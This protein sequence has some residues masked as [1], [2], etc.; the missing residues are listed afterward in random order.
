[1]PVLGLLQNLAATPVFLLAQADAGEPGAPLAFSPVK[2]IVVL[3]WVFLSFY[4]VKWIEDSPIVAPQY[5]PLLRVVALFVGPVVLV[6]LLLADTKQAA[7][8]GN[9][10][11]RAIQRVLGGLTR[12]LGA[13]A[14]EEAEE[15]SQLQLFDSLGTELRDLYGHGSGK[16]DAHVLD[17]T[18]KM[19]DNALR[20]RASD[21]LIDPK[22]QEAYAVRFRVDGTLRTI[23]ELPAET[24]KT[25][26]NSVK[27]VSNMDISERRRPQDGAF[28]AK[29]GEARFSFRVASAGALN[30]EK[31]SIRVLNQNADKFT[32]AQAGMPER[33]RLAIVSAVSKPSG[34]VLI[35][36]PTGSGKT[37]TLYSMLNQI[38]RRT[39]N[40][41]TVED[42][43]EAHL[44]ECSQLE[45]NPKADITFAK[46]LRSILRQDPDV[47]VVGEIRDEETAEIALR[48]AQ[49][50]HLVLATIHCDSNATALIRLLDLGVSAILMSTGLNLVVSQR[51][52]RKLCK[53]CRQPAQLAPAVAQRFRQKG[54]DPGQLFE[55]VGCERC[56]GT[57]Y[58]GRT[59]I[60]DMLPITE[61][62]RAE[63]AHDEGIVTKLR[64][65]G[66]KRGRSNMRLE[67]MARVVTG[68]SSLEEFKRVVG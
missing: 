42:P 20:Q 6:L 24:C 11:A 33:Q 5:A 66:E 62:L 55:A 32:L 65:E 53:A 23:R 3:S 19:I 45:I 61:Q 15:E 30:G 56:N 54:F 7:E 39:H 9:P 34:M 35:C 49:T 18:V 58:Y 40:V 48:A 41:I 1:M 28:T 60:C 43:I 4:V 10:F 25:V 44:P 51:L 27:A 59:A 38:D 14:E 16:A 52:M 8:R 67:A 36:G 26:I 68:I 46:A 63:I 31:L 64:N 50:G 47:I 2:L 29:K 37:T 12:A 21:I 57:G 13:Q 22:D 17:I